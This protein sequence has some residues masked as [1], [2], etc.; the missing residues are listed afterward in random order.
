MRNRA[1]TIILL[2]TA[3][4]SPLLGESSYLGPTGNIATPDALVVATGTW[5]IAY[6][7]FVEVFADADFI[8]TSINYGLL[9]KLEVGGAFTSNGEDDFVINAKYVLVPEVGER[10]AVAVGVFDA[11]STL[12]IFGDDPGFYVVATKNLGPAAESVTSPLRQARL[13]IGIGSGVYDG[14]FANLDWVVS[15][16]AHVLVE[17]I[18]NDLAKPDSQ[19]SSVNAGFRYGLTDMVTLDA[20]TIDF[21]DLAFG[22]SFRTRFR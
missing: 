4:A 20:A 21:E 18:N 12:D 19:G 16:R 1:L 22:V 5:E 10:P 7:Q 2:I 14:F 17:F 13:S 9:P 11:A 15:Q 3:F 6:H 8:T